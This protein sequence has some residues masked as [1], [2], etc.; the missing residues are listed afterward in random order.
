LSIVDLKT[1]TQPIASEDEK[2]RI[3]VNGEFY[4]HRAVRRDLEAKGHRFRTRSDSEIAVH[5]YEDHGTE[6]L[7]HLR[8]EFAFVIWDAETGRLFAARDRFGIKPLFYARVGGVLYLA[9]E[10][11]AL[12]AAGVPAAWDEGSVHANLFLAADPHRSLFR[13]VRQVP[14]GH[15]LTASNGTVRL[16]R[17]WDVDYPRAGDPFDEGECVERV[18]DLL[19]DSVRLRME[20]DVPVGCL[21][22]GGLDSSSI[23]G[24]ADRHGE[25]A[26]TS[27][28]IGFDDEDYDESGH[29]KQMADHVGGELIASSAN[30]AALADHFADSVWFGETV[31][32]NA[33]GTARYLLS[34]SVH[35]AGYKVVLAGEGADELFAGYEF[36][37]KAVR[38]GRPGSVVGRWLRLL[39]AFVR[40]MNRTERRLAETSR[41]L[42]RTGRLVRFPGPW[43]TN[44]ARGIGILRDV[45]S[46]A[47]DR[48]F[49]REDPY[50]NLIRRLDVS[51]R[52]RGREPVRQILYLWLKTL[53]VNYLL[54]A[55]RVD[56][57]HAVEVRLPFL[58]HKLFEYA[59]RI[60][61]SLLTRDGLEK[62]VLRGA[63]RPFVTESVHTREKRP[64]LAPPST[65]RPGSRLH[66]LVQET[67]RGATMKEIP[68]F[69][70]KRV[71]ALLDR[72]PEMDESRRVSL[73]GL[74][75]M[76]VSLSVLHERYGL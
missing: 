56:M 7:T 4:D 33:H 12:F 45:F 71:V 17:Y 47:F 40:P 10:A 11:K 55:D 2:V 29:A 66:E 23:L 35:A 57:A 13:D 5:L 59:S 26:P 15:F 6:C 70:R 61:A 3:V 67:L 9:S 38:S 69:D 25:S 51:G 1:G 21:L 39:A 28:T 41:W 53:F 74:L 32:L 22:S 63:V 50:A 14:A 75:M 68:F 58:D 24:I 34:R 20:A 43:L 62:H 8:G 36:C 31:Q 49:A 18:R 19:E 64:F 60:P 46:P 16:Q 76:M 54:A 30:D 37:R 48:R 27:F 72:M 42:V 44:M 73:D 65:L 52:L